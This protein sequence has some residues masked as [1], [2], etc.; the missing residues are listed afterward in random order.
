MHTVVVLALDGVIGFDLTTPLEVFGRTRLPDGRP[1]YRTRVC[2]P[3][4]DADAGAFTVRTASGLEALAEADTII[5]PGVADP[6]APLPGEAVD[7]L[8][9]AASAGTR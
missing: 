9:R 5:V 6:V 2:A 3:G 7:A 8:R 4:R 1:P